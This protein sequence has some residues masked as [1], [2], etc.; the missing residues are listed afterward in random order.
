MGDYTVSIIC[1]CPACAQANASLEFGNFFLTLVKDSNYRFA[2]SSTSTHACYSLLCI[3]YLLRDQSAPYEPAVRYHIV[4]AFCDGTVEMTKR[5]RNPPNEGSPREE[6][7]KT[8][9]TPELPFNYPSNSNIARR[10][11]KERDDEIKEIL[12]ADEKLEHAYNEYS[13]D[14]AR[15]PDLTLRRPPNHTNLDDRYKKQGLTKLEYD[16]HSKQRRVDKERTVSLETEH[17]EGKELL[18]SPTN[19][20]FEQENICYCREPDDGAG[21]DVVKCAG[22]YCLVACFHLRCIELREIP[23]GGEDFFCQDCLPYAK[24]QLQENEQALQPTHD[25]TATDT[26]TLVDGTESEGLASNE[27]SDELD[28]QA[29]LDNS[30]DA[31]AEWANKEQEI[32][33]GALAE[34]SEALNQDAEILIA[35]LEDDEDELQEEEEQ[36]SELAEP[37]ISPGFLA[38]NKLNDPRSYEDPHA[39]SAQLDG[40]LSP[41]RKHT[42]PRYLSPHHTRHQRRHKRT[43]SQSSAQVPLPAGYTSTPFH[44]LAPF[45]SP[46]LSNNDPHALTAEEARYVWCWRASC[47]PTSLLNTLSKTKRDE[48]MAETD[49]ATMGLSEWWVH[50]ANRMGFMKGEVSNLRDVLEN[51]EL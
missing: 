50:E 47:P 48:L 12:K 33:K 19:T 3:E 6:S 25:Q 42:S 32:I 36:G 2:Y 15:L 39:S 29:K 41:S 16:R 7:K 8:P 51:G 11:R 49:R 45:I 17:E 37:P 35:D 5:K 1:A 27:S 14:I 44:A 13:R 21:F 24:R 23:D 46:S 20:L 40:H 31:Q 38:V 22:E 18:P 4:E 43:N 34:I 26:S 28:D 9:Q 30:D 10:L